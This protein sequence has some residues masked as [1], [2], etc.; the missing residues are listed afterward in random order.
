M[1][2]RAQC[3]PLPAAIRVVWARGFAND[4]HARHGARSRT[5]HYLLLDD[6][7]PRGLLKAKVGWFH[8]PLDVTRDA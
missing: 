8:R 5:Y 3:H 1:G 4:F 6:S 7:S 2:A